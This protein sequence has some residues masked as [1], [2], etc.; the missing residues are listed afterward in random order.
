MAVNA[1]DLQWHVTVTSVMGAFDIAS[2]W[3]QESVTDLFE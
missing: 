2:T 1:W 3:A